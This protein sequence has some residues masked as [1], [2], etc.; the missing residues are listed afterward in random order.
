MTD[1]ITLTPTARNN[2]H[3]D[4]DAVYHLYN[5]VAHSVRFLNDEEKT[6]LLDRVLRIAEF[7]G[8]RPL[9]WCLM[10]N[11]F[12]ILI[13]LPRP[14]ELS[15]EEL[16]RRL[17][18]LKPDE[19]AVFYDG[20]ILDRAPEK[21]VER[22][23]NIGMFMKI[24]KENFTI[25]YNDRTGHHGTMWEGPYRFKKIPMCIKDLSNVA[26]YQNLNPVRACMASDYVSY[27]W[28]SFAAASQGDRRALSGIEFVFGGYVNR[29]NVSDTLVHPAEELVAMMR[30]KMDRDLE[31][32]QRERAEAVWRK[33]LAGEC[34]VEPDPLTTE[35]MVAQVEVQMA[36]LQSD[37][38]YEELSRA[39]GRAA[40]DDE[41]KVVR[42]MAVS[43]VAKTGDLAKVSG[44]SESRVKRIS[45]LLQGLGIISR[46]GTR[47]NSIW[48]L[49][50]FRRNANV[51]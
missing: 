22:M 8:I 4:P 3:Q 5:R 24:V 9:S 34:S 15:H 12:H 43:P 31:E 39:L 42:A 2:R 18:L 33:R 37:A 20:F 36:K 29:T 35:A 30:E 28:T 14:Q 41:V 13:Y 1:I 10:T 11:H 7:C 44:A 51:A 23:Y 17:K 48:R 46:E 32:Y 6:D 26:S 50:L 45:L 19:R 21:I 47:R 49:N 16:E 25:A 38:F 40:C 27:P